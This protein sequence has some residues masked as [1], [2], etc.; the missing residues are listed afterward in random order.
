MKGKYY[1]KV[2]QA[3]MLYG[4]R[5]WA[6][7]KQTSPASE[8][9][10]LRSMSGKTLKDEIR[11]EYIPKKLRDSFKINDKKIRVNPSRWL[12]RVQWRS[13]NVCS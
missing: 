8:M 7:K 4:S 5:C 11:N 1:K 2:I 9:K 3:A 10:K 13:I 6:I 12:G